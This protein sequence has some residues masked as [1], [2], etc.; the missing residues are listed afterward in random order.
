[1]NLNPPTDKSVAMKIA[2]PQNLYQEF[3]CGH[4]HLSSAMRAA[5]AQRI[6]QPCDSGQVVG[7]NPT[8]GTHSK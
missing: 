3:F 2:N 5:V 6:E 1:M 7:S 4:A 8:S